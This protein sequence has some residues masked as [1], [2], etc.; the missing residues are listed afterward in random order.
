MAMSMELE[1]IQNHDNDEHDSVQV[2]FIKQ[3]ESRTLDERRKEKR[4]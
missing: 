2:D 1:S 4:I 3:Q